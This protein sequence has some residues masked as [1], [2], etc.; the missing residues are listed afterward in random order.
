MGQSVSHAHICMHLQADISSLATWLG[1]KAD[2]DPAA[3]FGLLWGFAG[4]FDEAYASI[5]DASEA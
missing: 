5:A 1:E 3:L 4:A 2:T